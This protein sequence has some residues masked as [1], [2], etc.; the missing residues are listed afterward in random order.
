MWFT[1]LY[2]SLIP[3][4]S[5]LSILGLFLY[6]S[7]DKYNLLRRSSL[8]GNVSRSLSLT[9]MRLLDLTLLFRCAGEII[10]DLDLRQTTSELSIIFLIVSILFLLIPWNIFLKHLTQ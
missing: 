4:G 1:F 8:N 10:F 5:I 6:Y 9:A 7:V 3:F 2:G